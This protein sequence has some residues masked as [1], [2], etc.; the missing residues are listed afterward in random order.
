M[1][2]MNDRPSPRRARPKAA[3][4][5]REIDEALNKKTRRPKARQQ[6]SLG[7]QRLLFVPFEPADTFAGVR[8]VPV[9]VDFRESDVARVW[10]LYE[11]DKNK[12]PTLPFSP[13]HNHN[14]FIEDRIHDWN[15]VNGK[16]RYGSRVMDRDVWILVEMK[17]GRK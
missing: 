13:M 12:P 16:F 11:N 15:I 10:T 14:A 2:A 17:N 1:S 4:L 7:N 5:Q 6:L 3:Q 8:A 9:P